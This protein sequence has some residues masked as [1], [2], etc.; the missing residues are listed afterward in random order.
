MVT[1]KRPKIER[2]VFAVVVVVALIFLTAGAIL[3]LWSANE[4]RDLVGEQ[5]NAQ[6]LVLARQIS[7]LTEKQIHFL[8]RE[9]LFLEK[10]LNPSVFEPEAYYDQMQQAFQRALESGVWKIEILDLDR[11]RDYIFLPYRNWSVRDIP[12]ERLSI[13]PPFEKM[14]HRNVWISDIITKP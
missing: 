13:L 1:E 14:D 7:A 2:K 11:Q 8:E 4:T 12:P 10:Q 3:G 5:F 9:L 6:Q